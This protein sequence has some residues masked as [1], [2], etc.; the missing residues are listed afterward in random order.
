[1]EAS[2]PAQQYRYALLLREIDALRAQSGVT[3]VALVL[4]Q[5]DGLG[6]INR[7]YGFLAGD[8]VLAEF[9]ERMAGVGREQDRVVPVHGTRFA[10]VIH[11]PLHEGHAVL[12]ADKVAR[13]AAEPFVIGSQRARVRV[14]MGIS[15]LPEPARGADELLAQCE[16]ALRAARTRD[17]AYRVYTDGLCPTGGAQAHA[18]FDIEQAL[19]QGEFDMHFQ[20]KIDLRSG[21]L[22]GAEALVRWN[23]PEVG[24]LS[25]ASFIAAIEHTQEIR[26]LLRFALN[27]SLRRS[28][29][30]L[31][32]QPDFRIAVNLATGNLEDSDLVALTADA[33]KVWGFPAEQLILEVTE[34]A[35]MRDTAAAV[36]VLAALRGL[37]VRVS[38]DDF[39]TGYSSLA[40]LKSL[41]ADELKI[42]RS[43]I[44]GI[45][46]DETDR[47]I[48]E[49]V[50]R[51]GH[52]VQLKVVAEGIETEPVRETLVT[53]GCDIGQGYLYSPPLPQESFEQRWIAPPD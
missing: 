19:G 28:A 12:G 2:D 14:R 46:S 41:P 18:W 21:A 53:L 5:L 27:T 24:Q 48:V 22:Y 39:G 4:V 23:K 34:S 17:E 7:R 29:D 16:I 3:A 32:R 1:M 37:G 40:W 11:N 8:R 10:L 47:R 43:F 49:S 45:A 13:V 52:A 25:P 9:A 38:I 15:L 35:L 20:P 6:E 26:A 44:G 33:L 50:I 42:D 30:W 36:E 51:L 31:A